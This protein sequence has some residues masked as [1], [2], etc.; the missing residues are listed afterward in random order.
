MYSA[1][2]PPLRAAST[3]R[4]SLALPYYLAMPYISSDK[5]YIHYISVDLPLKKH[6]LY[7]YAY[8]ALAAM[9][10]CFGSDLKITGSG[11]SFHQ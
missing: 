6:T 1:S 9:P 11:V 8:V 5:P 10:A 3:L 7:A 2:V 4:P